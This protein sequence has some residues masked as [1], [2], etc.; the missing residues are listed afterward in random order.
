MDPSRESLLEH[1]VMLVLTVRHLLEAYEHVN[2][3]YYYSSS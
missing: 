1:I 3:R 2:S